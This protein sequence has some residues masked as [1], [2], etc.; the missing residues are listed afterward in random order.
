M[1]RSTIP[2]LDDLRAFEAVARL[3]SVRAAA[4]EL[5]LTHGA[6][7]RRISKLAVDI[8][9]QLFEPSGRGIR[10]TRDGEIL[11]KATLG[12]F[13]QLTD[14]LSEIRSSPVKQPIVLSCERSV[15]MRW[16]IPRLSKFQDTHPEIDLHLSV[17]GGTLDFQRDR[18][19]LAIRRLDFPV[20]PNWIIE[21]MM[22]ET[23]GPV[24]QPGMKV[25]FVNHNYIALGSKTRPNAWD[26]WLKEHPNTPRP[27]ENRF[28]DH[29]FL[30][31][32]GALNGLGVALCPYV[33][34]MD[35]IKRG[36][37]IA[38]LGFC[39]DGS[40]YGLIHPKE[41]PMTNHI[42]LV[43]HWLSEAAHQ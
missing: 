24:M 6:V 10:L 38:P 39:E 34:A 15:A 29:H 40:E 32:E 41:L 18:I 37:L 35:D 28:Q 5:A 3:G 12:A 22:K 11:S 17:G 7:S 2:S 23:I 13:E 1:K 14:A 9:V 25:H 20:D 16:L 36:R 30:M 26:D 4:E 21:H 31:I 27:R 43:K 33:L 8:N 42:K 19:T